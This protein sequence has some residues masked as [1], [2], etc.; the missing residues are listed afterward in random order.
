MEIKVYRNNVLILWYT[1]HLLY[2]YIYSSYI[3]IYLKYARVYIMR[4]TRIYYYTT[5]TSTILLA[6][7]LFKFTYL[8]IIIML[9]SRIYVE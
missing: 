5:T 1:M 7:I 9:A 4:Q 6:N 3:I 8:S 2:V